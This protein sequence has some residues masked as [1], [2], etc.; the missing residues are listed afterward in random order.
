M[1]CQWIN[2]FNQ[3]KDPNTIPDNQSISPFQNW[4]IIFQMISFPSLS[5]Q[6]D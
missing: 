6:S 3:S 4:L 5:E 2:S 1:Q